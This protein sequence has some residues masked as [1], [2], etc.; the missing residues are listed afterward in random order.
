M[1]CPE[2]CNLHHRLQRL[3]TA[4]LSPA[5]PCSH[6]TAP[7]RGPDVYRMQR[8]PCIMS[9]LTSASTPVHVVHLQVTLAHGK[10]VPDFI[11]VCSPCRLQGTGPVVNEP[12][13]VPVGV[14]TL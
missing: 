7:L 13:R 14:A 5:G 9:L 1:R 4:L 3:A 12:I 8:P 11:R 2:K 10:P 6:S